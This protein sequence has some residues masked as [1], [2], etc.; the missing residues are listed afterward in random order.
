M[1]C[2][3]KDTKEVRDCLLVATSTNTFYAFAYVWNQTHEQLSEFGDVVVQ[4]FGGGI[5]RIG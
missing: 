4:S 1:L 2:V 5:R 3:S